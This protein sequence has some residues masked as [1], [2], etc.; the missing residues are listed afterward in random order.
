MKNC[1]RNYAE[2]FQNVNGMRNENFSKNVKA[3]IAKKNWKS[4]GASHFVNENCS[5]TVCAFLCSFSTG[6]Y[7]DVN[8]TLLSCI[9]ILSCC[10]KLNGGGLSLWN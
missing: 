3:L 2:Q 9:L 1:V 10:A 5:V 6:I 8:L 4:S 7:Y